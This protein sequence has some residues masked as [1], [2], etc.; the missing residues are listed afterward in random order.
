MYYVYM[1]II[2]KVALGV[3]QGKKIMF[4]RSRSQENVFY[5]LGGKLEVGE[6]DIQCLK[7]E[8]KEEI[9]CEIEDS[10]IKFL[11]EF[12]DVAHGKEGLLNIRMYTGNLIGEPKPSAEVEEIGYFDSSSDKKNLSLIAQRTIFP[13]LKKH[14]FIN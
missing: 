9:G 10:S 2:R 3:F 1:Q 4:V 7:R 14:N 11:H 8:I 5:T 12:E 6:S 13:W